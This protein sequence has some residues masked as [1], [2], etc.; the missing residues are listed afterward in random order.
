MALKKIAYVNE[1][2]RCCGRGSLARVIEAQCPGSD[3]FGPIDLAFIEVSNGIFRSQ[4]PNISEWSAE[5]YAFRRRAC[6]TLRGKILSDTCSCPGG[7]SEL[8]NPGERGVST[9]LGDNPV[10][11]SSERRFFLRDKVR[12]KLQ[13]QAA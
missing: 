10:D 12:R 2:R 3:I 1:E 8:D 4:E 9:A 6:D 13:Q 7:T 11:E 5:V